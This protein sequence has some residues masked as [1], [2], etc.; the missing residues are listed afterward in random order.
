MYLFY[1]HSISYLFRIYNIKMYEKKEFV[2]PGTLKGTS[3]HVA[4]K[5][6]MLR[7]LTI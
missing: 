4:I 3:E 1:D 5:C 7:V 6:H 2:E